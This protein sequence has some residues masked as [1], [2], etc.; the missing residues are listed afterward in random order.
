M[1]GQCKCSQ[2]GESG[3]GGGSGKVESVSQHS[4]GM[5]IWSEMD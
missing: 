2:D 3:R 4:Q 5:P 1:P